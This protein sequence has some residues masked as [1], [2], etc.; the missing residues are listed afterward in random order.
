MLNRRK[1]LPTLLAPGLVAMAA[2]GLPMWAQGSAQADARLAIKGYDPVA[3]F[4]DGRPTL[5]KPE[6]ERTWDE[7]RYRFASAQHMTIFRADPDRYAPQFAG[8]CAMAMSRG[9]KVEA[10]PEVW[11][12][13]NGRLFVFYS[14]DG[15]SRFAA[16]PQATAGAAHANWPKLKDA[17]TGTRLAQ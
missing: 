15:R 12:I 7:V 4:T 17:P 6:F 10:D 8:S 11:L 5:G 13:S 2:I 3:Y 14:S 1:I 9:M 16:D